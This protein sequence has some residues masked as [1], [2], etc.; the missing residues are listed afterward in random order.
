M[1]NTITDYGHI[2]FEQI[3][4]AVWIV[5]AHDDGFGS[6]YSW[7]FVL[8]KVD[9]HGIAKFMVS[10]D[11]DDDHK[12]K[13]NDINSIRDFGHRHGMKYVEYTRLRSSGKT[14]HKLK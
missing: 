4:P 7:G 2:S 13:R 1:I 5:R 10:R 11:G 6:E 9:D 8:L 3:A 14:F 12:I